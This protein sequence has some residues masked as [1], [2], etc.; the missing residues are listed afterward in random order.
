M[1]AVTL[2]G[3]D[4]GKVFLSVVQTRLTGSDVHNVTLYM[5]LQPAEMYETIRHQTH[6]SA[7][8]IYIHLY[9]SHKIM[10]AQANKSG[11]NKNT[12]MKRKK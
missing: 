2:N 6:L 8:R 11:T 12:I 5:S 10:V 3:R 4:L 9:S 7:L 1:E